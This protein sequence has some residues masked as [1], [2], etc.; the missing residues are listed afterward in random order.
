EL[1]ALLRL[2]SGIGHLA[3][4]DEAGAIADAHFV[5]RGSRLTSPAVHSHPVGPALLERNGGEIGH[6]VGRDVAARVGHL[7]EQLF[8]R[9]AHGDRAA[10]SG[11]LAEHPF[12]FGVDVA[13]RKS[14]MREVGDVL[15]PGL[16]EIAA[17]D[18][19]GALEEVT[20]RGGA[21][22]ALP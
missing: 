10:G 11:D 20:D 4:A 5:R 6:Y 14:K 2:G 15:Q 21:P 7:V 13:P 12:T 9:G 1:C 16:C 8:F 22:E 19:T 17:R 18:L 3:F